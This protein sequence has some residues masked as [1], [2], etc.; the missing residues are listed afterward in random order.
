MTR[1]DDIRFATLMGALSVAFDKE[2]TEQKIDLYFEALADLR[3][4]ALEWAAKQ[5]IRELVFFPKAKELRDYAGIAPR[6]RVPVVANQ[7]QP[8]LEDLPTPEEAKRLLRELVET[9]N[10]KFGTTFAVGEKLG[11]PSLVS[12]SGGKS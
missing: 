1:G 7:H 4:E 2:L 12:L 10:G 6:P 3:I 9:L 5:V 8:L 11:R